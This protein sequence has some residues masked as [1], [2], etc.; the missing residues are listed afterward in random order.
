[1]CLS[2]SFF[3]IFLGRH[4]SR[5]RTVELKNVP[6]DTFMQHAI[7]ESI[8][9]PLSIPVPKSYED[10]SPKGAPVGYFYWMRPEDVEEVERTSDLPSKNGYMSGRISLDVGYD[11]SKDVFMGAEDREIVRQMKQA[12]GDFKMSRFRA[13][14]HPVLIVSCRAKQSGKLVYAM[15]VA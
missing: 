10:V 3:F 14:G 6:F 11:K 5:P 12:F 8:S 1:M 13:G 7:S 15:Y 9:I 4:V 2:S